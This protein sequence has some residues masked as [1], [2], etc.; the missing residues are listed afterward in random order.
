MRGSQ[1]T[2]MSLCFLMKAA[3]G[4]VQE[5]TQHDVNGTM[6]SAHRLDLKLCSK[7]GSQLHHSGHLMVAD[8]KMLGPK[9]TF[10]KKTIK[11]TLDDDAHIFGNLDGGN[12]AF[13]E[14][15]EEGIETLFQTSIYGILISRGYSYGLMKIANRF[16]LTDSH[17]CGSKGE[18]FADNG[19][20][21]IMSFEE[22]DTFM[23][24]IRQRVGHK[25]EQFTIDKVQI[26]VEQLKSR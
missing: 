2:V 24:S 25:S 13:G 11:V 8:L 22:K 23:R 5:L 21:C 17:S 12:D 19:T 7:L 9:L 26:E 3:I 20:A 4:N 10:S 1:C 6:I 16:Y 18:P 15:L 14:N